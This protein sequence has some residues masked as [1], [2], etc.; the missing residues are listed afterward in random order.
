MSTRRIAFGDRDPLLNYTTDWY[1]GYYNAT[2]VHESGTLASANSLAARVTFDFPEPAV[3]FYYYGILRSGGGS[4]GICF[5]CNPDTPNYETIDGVNRTDNGQNP[6]VVLYSRTFST[7]ELHR[8]ILTNRRDDRFANG[9]SQITLARFELE[10]PVNGPQSSS[11]GT[12]SSLETSPSSVTSTP[13]NPSRSR[14]IGAIAGGVL[15]GCAGLLALL[16]MLCIWLRRRRRCTEAQRPS[17]RE[18][19]IRSTPGIN[20]YAI[21]YSEAALR[22]PIGK[23]S[24]LKPHH[25]SPSSFDGSS[26]QHSPS[27]PDTSM[28]IPVAM[29]W[30]YREASTGRVE[31]Q[32]DDG[33]SILPPDYEQ[34][35]RSALGRRD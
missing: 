22:D 13:A 30:S 4:Y 24:G 33:T 7:P 6:P 34:V 32:D 20:P 5:D 26:Q 14:N 31:E 3:G 28:S 27:D 25:T 35:F 12:S 15:G 21:S 23:R 17:L 11:Q 9:T 2:S 18:S 29:Q 19:G 16:A 8:V 1:Q 10:V